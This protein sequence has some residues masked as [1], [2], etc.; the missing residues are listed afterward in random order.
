MK[1]LS[2]M[3]PWVY[4]I[5]Q[6]GKDVE[7]RVWPT[8]HSGPLVICSS[9]KIEPGWNEGT[10]L[11][12]RAAMPWEIVRLLP[13]RWDHFKTVLR[14]GMALGVVDLVHCQPGGSNSPWAQPGQWHWLLE[15]PRSFDRPFPVKGSLGLWDINDALVAAALGAPA[16]P[17]APE[18]IA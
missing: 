6:L 7:N 10:Y 15:N 1:A 3:E 5:F 18:D 16:S 9:A 2:V 17:P 11:D 14:P 13:N 8:E 4:A 12:W